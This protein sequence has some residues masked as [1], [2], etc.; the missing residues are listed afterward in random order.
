[1]DRYAELIKGTTVARDVL[2]G[3]DVRLDNDV[4]LE[5]RATLLLEFTAE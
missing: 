3:H 5:P 2:T 4:Q 1:M